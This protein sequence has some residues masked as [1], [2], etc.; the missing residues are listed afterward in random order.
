[1]AEY[2]TRGNDPTDFDP[3][4]MRQVR[5]SEWDLKLGWGDKSLSV[6]GLAVVILIAV[7]IVVGAV[8][9]EAYQTEVQHRE[10]TR[11][12]DQNSCILTMSP[13]ERANFRKD[14]G[15]NAFER[16]CWWVRAQR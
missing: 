9:Y 7:G 4:Q 16:W 8:L 11:G 13:E 6:R 15:P 14:V 3:R 5:P 2:R 1:M 10:L 12:Q